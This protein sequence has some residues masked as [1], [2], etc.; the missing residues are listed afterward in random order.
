V[1]LLLGQAFTESGWDLAPG[2]VQ[3]VDDLP[4]YAFSLN[5][6][7]QLQP[8]AEAWLGERASQAL[9]E[10]GVMP[11]LSHRQRAS[12]RLTRVQSIAEPAQ[13]LA[14]PWR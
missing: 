2:Q 8:C 7:A 14:G 4:A 3:D 9:L 10:Q 1:A 13:P 5:D 11:L 12:V 6:E